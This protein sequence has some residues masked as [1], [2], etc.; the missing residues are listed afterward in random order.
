MAAFSGDGGGAGVTSRTYN[1]VVGIAIFKELNKRNKKL[2][3]FS[4][5]KIEGAKM[6]L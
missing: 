4:E 1:H 6:G 5:E 3:L 2:L